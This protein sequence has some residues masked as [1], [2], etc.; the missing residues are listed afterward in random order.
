MI[1]A[2]WWNDDWWAAAEGSGL[3][4]IENHSWDHNHESL[5]RTEATCPRGTFRL[6]RRDEADAEIRDANDYLLTTRMRAGPALFA[7]PYGEASEFLAREYFPRG[8]D[9]HGIRAAFTTDGIPI[10]RRADRWCLPR[11]VFRSHWDTEA[12]LR[13]ILRECRPE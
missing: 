7:Y 6:E 8:T 3:L 13:R 2:Q 5:R 10:T 12:E 4:R 1:G 9:V 11:Y